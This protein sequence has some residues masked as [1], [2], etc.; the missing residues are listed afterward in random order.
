MKVR[1]GLT[2]VFGLL[3]IVAAGVHPFPAWAQQ[4]TLT[5]LTWSDYVPAADKKFVEQ[6]NRFGK[7]NNVKVEVNFV[8]LGD[9]PAKISAAAMSKSGPDIVNLWYGTPHVY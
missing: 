5:I 3:F 2:A 8:S 1:V 4:K 7:Q 6:A 9:L